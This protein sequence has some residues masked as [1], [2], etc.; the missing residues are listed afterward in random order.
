MIY[1][2]VF[3]MPLQVLSG[4]VRLRSRATC[5]VST[6]PRPIRHEGGTD[7]LSAVPP[8]PVDGRIGEADVV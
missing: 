3:K 5:F 2:G 1:P 7:L 4:R 6:L 8:R